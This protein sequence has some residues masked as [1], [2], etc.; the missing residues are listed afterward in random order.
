VT[1]SIG[2]WILNQV[3]MKKEKNIFHTDKSR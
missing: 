1:K 3:R 2:K